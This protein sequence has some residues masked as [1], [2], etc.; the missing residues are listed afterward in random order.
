M[1]SRPEAWA[2]HTEARGDTA[3]PEP[4]VL[5]SDG[6]GRCHHDVYRGRAGALGG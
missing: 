3:T 1:D 2:G 6:L 5:S 4:A